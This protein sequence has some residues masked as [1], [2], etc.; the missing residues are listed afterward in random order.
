[1]SASGSAEPISPITR[2]TP[3]PGVVVLEKPKLR[4]ALFSRGVAG[5]PFAG[6][7]IG[8]A[9]M[10]ASRI[11]SS[12]LVSS[13]GSFWSI[14][15]PRQRLGR[16]C[17]ACL[18][19][20]LA[21]RPAA[22]E[23][24]RVDIQGPAFSPATLT[25]PIG[26]SVSWEN[27]EPGFGHTTTSDLSTSDPDYWQ[28]MMARAGD[29]ISHTFNRAGV[30]S[31]HDQLDF[32]MGVIRVIAPAARATL[33]TPRQQDGKFFF[34]A[35]GLTAGNT[36]VLHGS[37][38]LVEWSAL[39]TN[40]AGGGSM[41]FTNA[42][43]PGGTFFRLE[44]AGQVP[45]L[46]QGYDWAYES[47][48][49]QGQE[50]FGVSALDASN[51]WA[52]GGTAYGG[53]GGTVVHFDGSDWRVQL[54]GLT[55]GLFGVCAIASNHVWAVGTGGTIL[56]YDGARWR[57]QLSGVSDWLYGVA[58][59]DATNVWAVGDHGTIL[60]FDGTTWSRQSSGTPYQL[61]S[62]SVA[63][64]ANIWAA[65]N[66]GTILHYDG[67][68]WSAQDAGTNENLQAISARTATDVWAV[69][70]RSTLLHY[71]GVGWSRQEPPVRDMP[72]RGV[73]AL[74]ANCVWTVGPVEAARVFF[75]NGT[76]WSLAPINKGLFYA[77]SALD[78][79]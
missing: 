54:V 36:N 58:A 10:N 40:V 29:T 5:L 21:L 57:Q 42:A 41:S 35:T 51:V 66:E 49:P 3:I 4:T 69:G 12:R 28:G 73:A 7:G 16:V 48:L 26:D 59:A 15:G 27:G 6:G 76:Q 14:F 63:D 53:A 13:V 31:Y 55:H 17:G 44:E 74:A 64:A 22:A 78:S 37:T 20:V 72:L 11:R 79:V 25:I 47:P 77:V 39:G 23:T 30:Y 2:I 18:W 34:E 43:T 65:G 24:H 75:Y 56:H 46:G 32:G 52:V 62:I 70:L 33:R 71:D 9:L 68:Q 61:R 19:V 1:M 8:S 38:N 45:P 50:L 60:H 67:T